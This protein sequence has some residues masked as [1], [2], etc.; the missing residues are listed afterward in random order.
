ME[1]VFPEEE[2]NSWESALFVASVKVG[3]QAKN[4]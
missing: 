3:P 1:G 4:R 2:I